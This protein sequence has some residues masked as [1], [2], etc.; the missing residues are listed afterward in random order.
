MPSDTFLIEVL[1]RPLESA[2]YTAVTVRDDGLVATGDAAGWIE[3]RSMTPGET[4]SAEIAFVAAHTAA[5]VDVQWSTDSTVLAVTDSG[6]RTYAMHAFDEPVRLDAIR[7]Q[8]I[9]AI[10]T[11][12]DGALV[13]AL[14]DGSLLV[15]HQSEVGRVGLPGGPAVLDPRPGSIRDP[16]L[17]GHPQGGFLCADPDGQLRRWS[18]DGHELEAVTTGIRPLSL[19]VAADRWALLGEDGT[20]VLGTAMPKLAQYSHKTSTPISVT[21]S[22]DGLWVALIDADG[23][24]ILATGSD[25]QQPESLPVEGVRC[26]AWS[27]DG[28]LL[29]IGSNDGWIEM[30][31]V[32]SWQPV[33]RM[34]GSE[35][36]TSLAWSSSGRYLAAGT[37]DGLLTVAEHV[38]IGEVPE[39]LRSRMKEP[40]TA[41]E[42]DRYGIP[43]SL[44]ER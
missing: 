9:T 35:A 42:R 1:R 29:A 34:L 40:M 19:T 4:S 30:R 8:P 22:P 7:G 13:T 17:V 16:V 28:Q 44:S 36:V 20:L 23:L 11:Q 39:W 32:G 41:E 3:V 21:L 26:S 33:H 24:R 31:A 5:L 43:P 10:A 27:P 12:I 25:A 37:E 38:G 14:A 15:Y 18:H 2:R 6:I